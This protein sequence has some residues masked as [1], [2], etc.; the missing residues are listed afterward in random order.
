MN[1]N[2]IDGGAKRLFYAGTNDL[3][4]SCPRCGCSLDKHRIQICSDERTFKLARTLQKHLDE[5]AIA[6]F[7]HGYDQLK[8]VTMVGAAIAVIGT[9]EYKF[10]TV[11]GRD[12]AV[13]NAVRGQALGND[14]MFVKDVIPYDDETRQITL[15]L[16]SGG[17]FKTGKPA[18]GRAGRNFTPGAC[19]APKLLQAI[20]KQRAALSGKPPIKSIFMSEVYWKNTAM[21]DGG[22]SSSI[23]TTNEPTISCDTCKRLLPIMMCDHVE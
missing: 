19:A 4:S 11:S 6:A 8:G 23:W 2:R 16:I 3:I 21:P 1:E 14:V 13:L 20:F 12:P 22:G 5:V 10:A 15:P 7:S 18:D 9:A 17:I